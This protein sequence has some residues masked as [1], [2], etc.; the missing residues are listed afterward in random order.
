MTNEHVCEIDVRSSDKETLH[1]CRVCGRK[2]VVKEF[3]DLK[4][5]IDSRTLP[6]TGIGQTT[7]DGRW[8]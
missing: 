6:S 1:G 2:Y 3:T 8:T 4:R 7:Q 5:F